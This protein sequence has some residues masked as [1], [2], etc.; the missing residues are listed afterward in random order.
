MKQNM[1]ERYNK[2]TRQILDGLMAEHPGENVAFSPYSILTLLA[3]AAN[4]SAGES[5]EQIVK[6]LGADSYE[7]LLSDIDRLQTKLAKTG[8]LSAANAALVNA[9]IADSITPGYDEQLKKLFDGSLI[10]SKDMI[11]DV[12]TWVKEKTDGQICQI[13]D[14]SMNAMLACLINAILFDADWKEKYETNDIYEG[15]FTNADGTTSA[16]QMLSSTEWRYLENDFFTGFAKPYKENYSYVALLP[17]KAKSKSFLKRAIK[18]LDIPELLRNAEEIKTI[19]EMPE[20]ETAFGQDITRLCQNMGITEIFTPCAD[21]S[22][23]SSKWL[24]MDQIV[25]KAKIEVNRKGTR[26]AAVTMGVMVAGCAPDFKNIRFVTL[27]RPFLY[28]VVHNETGL[29]VFAGM[30]NHPELFTAIHIDS[31]GA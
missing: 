2:L 6:A 16:V 24:R 12:N 17:K 4:A 30:V 25:H 26:A 28:A 10:M 29:P 9:S 31:I 21:F 7:S 19:V 8:Q 5:R 22:P 1:I 15:D 3:I 13:A 18:E 14:E 11:S 20:F 23:M 27:D